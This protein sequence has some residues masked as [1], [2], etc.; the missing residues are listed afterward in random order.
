LKKDIEKTLAVNMGLFFLPQR[1][2][3]G[4]L[5]NLLVAVMFVVNS[6]K[7]VTAWYPQDDD[8]IDSNA[9]TAKVIRAWSRL[10]GSMIATSF[11]FLSP[12]GCA[13]ALSMV[14][15]AEW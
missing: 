3:G 12:P 1:P 7:S 4:K 5:I 8:S 13:R 9:E 2:A 6:M 14:A 10:T 11:G 15:T